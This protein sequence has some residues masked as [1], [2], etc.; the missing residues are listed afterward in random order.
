MKKVVKRVASLLLATIIGVTSVEIINPTEAY[1]DTSSWSF[2]YT[3]A[4][5]SFTVP[6]TGKYYIE[7]YGAAGGGAYNIS[8]SIT[9]GGYGG[10]TH[11]YINLYAG[12]K[13]YISVGQAGSINGGRTFGGGGAAGNGGGS[14]GGAT[15]IAFKS[16]ALSSLSSDANRKQ[17]IA[18]AG[19]GGGKYTRYGWHNGM[20]SGGGL[21]GGG[22]VSATA[23]SQSYGYAFGQGQDYGGGVIG[24]AGG[25]GWYGGCGAT[26][27]VHGGSGGSSYIGGLYDAETNF[28][29]HT[30]NGTLTI[31]YVGEV[32]TSLELQLGNHISYNGKY[33]NVLIEGN[34]GDKVRINNIK[35]D[36]GY[37]FERWEV[38]SGDFN[39]SGDTYTFGTSSCR[40]KALYQAPLVLTG[41]TS[42]LKTKSIIKLQWEQDDPYDKT[43]NLYQSIDNS[44]WN[45]IASSDDSY[46]SQY[47]KTWDSPGSYEYDIKI[48]GVY[49]IRL[50]GAQGSNGHSGTGGKG[51]RTTA[52]VKLNA[53]TK[54]YVVVGG[55]D[56]TNGGGSGYSNSYGSSG[57]GGGA[58][59]IATSPGYLSSFSNASNAS[60]YVIAVA[61]GGG[62]GGGQGSRGWSA[63]GTGNGGAGGQT[64]SNGIGGNNSGDSISD[65]LAGRAG[66]GAS[67]SGG[68]GGGSTGG[69]HSNGGDHNYYRGCG[70]GGG[71]GWFGGG[72]GGSGWFDF[73][74]GHGQGYS[75]GNGYFGHGGN[76]G[77]G[78]PM[79]SWGWHTGAGGGGGGG[80]S[81]TNS[82]CTSVSYSSGVRAGNGYASITLDASSVVV[83]DN[84]I[85]SYVVDTVAPY[86]PSSCEITG[87][88][89]GVRL[90][91]NQVAD[92]GLVYYYMARSYINGV[93]SKTSSKISVPALSGLKGYYY[94]LDNNSTGTATTSH[95]FTYDEYADLTVN[96]IINYRYIHIAAIDYAGNLSG[97]YNFYIPVG[98]VITFD[99]NDTTYN[100]Y[101]DTCTT[102]AT[103]SMGTQ[104]IIY[105]TSDNLYKNAYSKKGYTFQGWNTKPNGTGDSFTQQQ[106]VNY[107]NLIDK[108]GF[109]LTLYAQWKPI[110]YK[111][112]YDKGL[113]SDIVNSAIAGATRD[114]NIQQS[115]T[116]RPYT[117]CRFDGTVKFA[118]IGSLKG[119]EYTIKYD[120]NKPSSV[121]KQKQ[122]NSAIP[123]TVADTKGNLP[124]LSQWQI[125]GAETGNGTKQTMGLSVMYPNYSSVNN[126]SAV[127]TALWNNKTIDTF[128]SPTLTGWVFMGWYDNQK[129][130]DSANSNDTS[131]Y[132]QIASKKIVSETIYPSTKAFEKTL[133]ARWQRTIHL[134][135]NMNKG[136]YQGSPNNVILTGV[137]YNNANGY[138]F[139]LTSTPTPASLPDYE[140]QQNYIDAYGVYDSNGENSKYVYFDELTE[141]TYRF[142]GWSLDPNATEP[143]SDFIVFDSGHKVNYR[144]YDDTTLYAV[145]EPVLVANVALKRTLGDLPFKDGS[146]P[147]SEA[148]NIR[149][150]DGQQLV[151]V[152]AK[153]GEQCYYTIATKG[154]NGI[155][156]GIRFD[157][158][159]LNIYANEGIWNDNL[160]PNTGTGEE[161]LAYCGLDRNFTITENYLMRKFY[162]PQ[163]LGTVN[164]YPSSIG[165]L[166][167]Q[168]L[169]E[170]AQDSYFYTYVYGMNEQVEVVGT[171]YISTNT[172]PGEDPVP[173]TPSDPIVSVL[174]ELRAKLKVKLR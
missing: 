11:G 140:K 130:N 123:T 67:Q 153:P 34:M 167:Y 58:T 43:I 174:D 172:K 23:P 173:P 36:S 66:G 4:E 131:N 79:Y 111:L 162:I 132:K 29:R 152:I 92:R 47:S 158:E 59:H 53:G 133:Y 18:V 149:C 164:S 112:Y 116:N 108:Y 30:G 141:T 44:T 25:G 154:K 128:T 155:N 156:A 86:T 114:T 122:N 82:S 75:G 121:V 13:I 88:K 109:T 3:G 96:D 81:W 146:Y 65:L 55:Q 115:G 39:L 45:I 21:Y 129:G 69:H 5:T 22:T 136:Q 24:G 52:K 16:G 143:D 102:T 138:N 61:A 93:Q 148:K 27:T 1:A 107:D 57:C 62:G 70:G 63:V 49:S 99:K 8:S 89:N 137:Y 110:E 117:Q 161:T 74:S 60:K 159:I 19:G 80:S 160:N 33:G 150:S 72:G 77:Q 95:K 68:G 120:G 42:E 163:Y 113:T 17:V 145:W 168:V 103:G 147:K 12:Q 73:E 125:S 135:F 64:G 101:G 50:D 127:A 142:L 151:E 15:H 78:S 118:T 85:G 76:G 26:E 9:Q 83:G 51:A 119:R 124:S 106:L 38:I 2:G 170:I 134:T 46:L 165:K 171:I 166:Q 54:L 126:G 20:G 87:D 48:S 104:I 10:Y 90:I 41:D 28:S 7:M 40:V 144:I 37:T 169:F 94:Y 91:W 6:K 97:T 105:G 32:K 100:M 35:V 84:T 157:N 71:G 139:S 56:G 31:K 14:G 98:V